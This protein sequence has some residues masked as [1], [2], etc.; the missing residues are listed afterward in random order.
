[1]KQNNGKELLKMYDNCK[2]HIRAIQLSKHFNLDTLFTIA[3]EL[4]MDEMTR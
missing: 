1:M 4:N 2:Q 3:M